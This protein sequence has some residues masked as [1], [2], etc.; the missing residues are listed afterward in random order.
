MPA[1]YPKSARLRKA[2][3]FP[4]LL[5]RGDVFPGR[6]CLVRRLPNGRTGARLGISTPRKYGGSV[7]RN[8][9]RRLVR[10]AFR[11]LR[12]QLGPNDYLVSPRK[13]LEEPSF[14]GVRADLLATL[15]RAPA[16]Q[17]TSTGR[18][19]PGSGARAG[20]G[21]PRAS[22]AGGGDEPCAR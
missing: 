1:S 20:D 4:A 3:D 16:P 11:T 14:E 2:R 5:S 17:R 18:R 12:E 19:T 8:R 15:T 9:F 7:R 10:E 13:G 21:G 6:Q 22:R